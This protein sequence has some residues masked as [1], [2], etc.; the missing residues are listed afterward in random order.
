MSGTTGVRAHGFTDVIDYI[1]RITY[2]IWNEPERDP[3][4][5][6]RYYADDA[7]IHLDAGDVNGT[8]AVIADTRRRQARFPDFDGRID[9]TVWAGDED[10]GYRTSMRWTWRATDLGG[11]ARHHRRDARCRSRASRTA[12]SSG[13]TSSRSG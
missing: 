5:I 13:G 10:H 1:E 8:H 7:V 3:T 11:P 4:L 12:S 9:E 6:Q 2:A